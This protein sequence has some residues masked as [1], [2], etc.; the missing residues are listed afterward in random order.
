MWTFRKNN[1]FFSFFEQF[2]GLSLSLPQNVHLLT[3]E[4]WK[5]NSIL[6]RFEHILEKGEDDHY[7]QPATFNIEDVFRGLNI[8]SVRETTLSAN[9]WLDEAKRL[10]FT[11]KIENSNSFGTEQKESERISSAKQFKNH[12]HRSFESNDDDDL[13]IT[14]NPMEIRTFIIELE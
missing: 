5:S 4:P 12:H 2:S 11:N 7:S 6:I 9:Q 8:A 3:F 1:I 13:T 10:N 14:L